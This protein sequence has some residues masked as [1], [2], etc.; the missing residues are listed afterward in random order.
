MREP[1]DHERKKVLVVEDDPDIRKI[2]Q[3]FLTEKG[4]SVKVAAEPAPAL[5]ILAEEPFDL[6][7]SDVRMPGMTGLDLLRHLKE[8]DPE[9]QLVLM[10]AYS[11]VKDAVEAIQLGAADYVEK[12]IDFRRLERVIAA[13]FEKRSLAHQT[14]IMQQRLQGCVVFEGMIGRGQRMLETFAFIERL[15][16]YPTTALVTGESG[17]GKELVARAL[18]RLSPLKDAPFVV[19]NCTTLAPS[20]LESELFGHV[21]GSFTGADRDRKGL[22]EAAHGGTIFLDEI[23]ELPLGVQVKLLR[24]LE[25]REIKRVGSPDAIHIDIRVIAAT[26][27]N[28]ADMV[29]AGTFRDDLYYRLNVG[30]IHLPPLRE[31]TEDI[32]PLASHFIETFNKKLGKQVTGLTPEALD[33]LLRAPWPGNVRELSN[34]IERAMIV[35]K[36]PQIAVEDLPAHLLSPTPPAGEAVPAPMPG[37]PD[38]S[39]EAAERDQ[40]RRALEAAAGRRVAAARLLGLSRRTLYRKLDKYGL[41]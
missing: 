27:R 28:L 21:R 8:R 41:H 11:C 31:R 25:N 30:A 22:F 16:R 32:E 40:I 12:P 13:V 9:I 37:T 20:L 39:L 7:L 38:L 33:V 26:N 35:A 2:L 5:E 3:L 24:V 18:H 4:F 19:C 34:V 17:T 1:A 6:I 14:R 36:R 29:A 10:T 15:A 23:G